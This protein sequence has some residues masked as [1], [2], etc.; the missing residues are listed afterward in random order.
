MTPLCA[1]L[2]ERAKAVL[3]IGLLG[4]RIAE[5]MGQS[6]SLACAPTYHCGDLATA[7]K[8]ARGIATAGDVVL[9]S[10]GLR[11]LRPIRELR[12]RGEAFAGRK[13]TMNVEC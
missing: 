1:A 9:L 13:L 8:M 2:C 3:C 4:P 10:P 7:V 12:K 6:A 11:E 5:Q